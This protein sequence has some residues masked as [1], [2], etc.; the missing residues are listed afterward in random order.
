MAVL[1]EAF[2]NGFFMVVTVVLA[3]MA[4]RDVCS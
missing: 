1:S 2:K 4:E 3:G